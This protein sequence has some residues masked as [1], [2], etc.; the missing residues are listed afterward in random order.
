[1]ALI[2]TAFVCVQNWKDLEKIFSRKSKKATPNQIHI[3]NGNS[4]FKNIGIL[5]FQNKQ[6]GVCIILRTGM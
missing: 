4:S 6:K 1:M 2:K 5:A 3:I